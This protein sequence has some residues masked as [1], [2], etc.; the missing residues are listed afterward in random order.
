M[1]VGGEYFTAEEDA[2]K[3]KLNEADC[4]GDNCNVKLS[5]VNCHSP[6]IE[7]MLLSVYRQELYQ[8]YKQISKHLWGYQDYEYVVVLVGLAYMT[9]EACSTMMTLSTN[10]GNFIIMTHLRLMAMV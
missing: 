2:A 4:Y 3:R 5:N 9:D 7:W 6:N 10:T 1:R 8:F